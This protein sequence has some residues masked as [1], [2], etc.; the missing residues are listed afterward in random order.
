[1]ELHKTITL[2]SQKFDEYKREKVEREKIIKMQKNAER[3]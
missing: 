3:Y 2:I 1:M